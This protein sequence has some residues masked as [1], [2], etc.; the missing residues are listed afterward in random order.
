ME[1]ELTKN[2]HFP[3]SVPPSSGLYRNKLSAVNSPRRPWA[4]AA[5]WFLSLGP[6]QPTGAVRAPT[7]LGPAAGSRRWG[8]ECRVCALQASPLE[9]K[10]AQVPPQRCAAG[11]LP[12]L[13]GSPPSPS[14]PSREALL[15]PAAAAV[16][17]GMGRPLPQT[18]H[19][20]AARQRA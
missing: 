11:H 19:A 15:A 9:N 17:S 5:L 3:D 4:G 8:A 14:S 1:T 13:L 7:S 18:H 12:G 16:S 20:G 6:G 2:S 10:L